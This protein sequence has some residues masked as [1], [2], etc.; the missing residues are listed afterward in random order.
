[1][2]LSSQMKVM[3]VEVSKIQVG[4]RQRKSFQKMEELAQ[5]IQ[6]HGL[7]QPLVVT[8]EL[9][10][11][12]GERR[13]R[14]CKSLGLKKVPAVLREDLDEIRQKEL[15]LE[16]NTQREDLSWV[17]VTLARA[18]LHKL[19][20]SIYGPAKQGAPA[21]GE[22]EQ[23]WSLEDTA[24][25]LGISK[26]QMSM[27]VT[28]AEKLEY[29]PDLANASSKREA[30]KKLNRK[31][32]E[33]L[34]HLLATRAQK[35]LLAKNVIH[36]DCLS[37]MKEMSDESVHLIIADPPF[38]V[39]LGTDPKHQSW[40][41]EPY[42]DD[43]GMVFEMLEAAI[44]EFYRI[45]VMNS[46]AYIFFA[47]KLQEPMLQLLLKS[48]DYVDRVPYIWNKGTGG[49]PGYQ[50]SQPYA[51]EPFFFCMKGERKPFQVRGEGNVFTCKRVP[52]DRKIH[53]AEK[54]QGLIL[55]LITLSS[56]P[57]DVVFDP[58]GGS[59]STIV[60]AIRLS[61]SGIT[62]EKIEANYLNIVGRVSALE[63]APEEEEDE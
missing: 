35:T 31:E 10:L 32:R 1:M 49:A 41:K 17:E 9:K 25:S 54:P 24:V 19:K 55:Q 34:S 53:I 60:A 42:P 30:V 45:L 18:E 58:F 39:N 36:G 46:H 59:G 4:E 63:V 3:M 29:F 7:L 5:S 51:Y 47:S 56:L 20:V 27:D 37:V 61:R 16:E 57:G 40:G 26:A 13:L 44:P 15:E 23:G 22:T 2:S 33:A 11:V 6:D 52:P 38:G 28:L 43:F 14:A 12:A 48:F 50:Y 21:A 62:C 8:E